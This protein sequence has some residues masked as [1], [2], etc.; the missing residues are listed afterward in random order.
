MFVLM[1]G[2]MFNKSLMHEMEA[3]EPTG[4]C[5]IY[6]VSVRMPMLRCHDECHNNA[7]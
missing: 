6:A 4:A 3:S 7:T 1:P 2:D 5:E